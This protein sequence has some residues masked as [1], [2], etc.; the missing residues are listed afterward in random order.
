MAGRVNNGSNSSSSGRPKWE[1]DQIK[2]FV[3]WA[4]FR[5][6]ASC[7]ARGRPVTPLV[8][9]INEDFKYVIIIIIVRKTI[10]QYTEEME[11]KQ[12]CYL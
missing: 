8:T 2:S 5:W 1:E 6:G 3:A 4:N 12:Q 10:N 11:R 7:K 9:D